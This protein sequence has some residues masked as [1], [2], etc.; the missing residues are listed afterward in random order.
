KNH[1]AARLKRRCEDQMIWLPDSVE[2][3]RSFQ[4]VK[5][6]VGPTGA[7]RLD[8]NRTDKGHA[9]EFW[10]TA[11]MC[12]AIEEPDNHMPLSDD[13]LTGRPVAA[14]MLGKVF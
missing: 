7:V 13:D 3:R 2:L 5:R 11:L 8:A 9:D 10:A 14:G 1:L 6:Y 12:G 4:A